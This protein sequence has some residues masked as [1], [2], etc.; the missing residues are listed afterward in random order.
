RGMRDTAFLNSQRWQEQQWRAHRDGAHPDMLE[1]ERLF[2]KRLYKLGIPMFVHEFWRTQERQDELFAA[3][4]SLAKA[5]EGPHPFGC[6]FDLIHS[7]HGW[8]LNRQQW[9]LIGHVGKELA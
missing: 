5:G 6:A 9:A 1:Y 4:K 8:G 3:G 7:V 2:L